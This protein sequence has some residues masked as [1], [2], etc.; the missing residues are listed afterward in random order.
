MLPIQLRK[1]DSPVSEEVNIFVTDA[2]V[3]VLITN[4]NFDDESILKRVDRGLALRN[5]L[6]QEAKHNKVFLPQVDELTW[7]GTRDDYAEKAKTV[8]VLR[9]QNEDLRSLKEL[10]VYG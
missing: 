9:E 2:F 1:A 3:F 5:G 10:L 4:A 8:G 6:I 7:Q